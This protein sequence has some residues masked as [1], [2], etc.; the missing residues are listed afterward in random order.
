VRKTTAE[1]DYIELVR[2]E[3][4]KVAYFVKK[5]EKSLSTIYALSEVHHNGEN[6]FEAVQAHEDDRGADR[7]GE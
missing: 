1:D 7:M 5:I 6:E 2:T 4:V 3:L